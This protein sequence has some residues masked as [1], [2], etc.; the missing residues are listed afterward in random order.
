MKTRANP[1]SPRETSTCTGCKTDICCLSWCDHCTL[2]ACA[3]SR[4]IDFCHECKEFPCQNL[5]S[6]KNDPLY[7]Y[8]QEVYGYLE[9]IKNKGK[10]AWL[11]EMKTRW[12]CGSCGTAFDWWT[13]TC[14]HCGKSVKGY[15]NPQ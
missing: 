2:K 15:K 9:T 14:S 3:K 1:D 13:Q 5:E 10:Q 6:F 8:H 7:P 12:S 11:A 4:S